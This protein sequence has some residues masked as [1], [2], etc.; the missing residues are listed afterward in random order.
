LGYLVLPSS[1]W[2]DN[3]YRP[4]EER[5]PAFLKRHPGLPEAAEIVQMQRQEA[6]LYMR[7]QDWFGYGFYVA[8]KR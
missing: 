6:D 4:T 1:N 7:Y 8:R 5:I 2:L 3:Y